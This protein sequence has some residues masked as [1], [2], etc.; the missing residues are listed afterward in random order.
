MVGFQSHWA[1]MEPA[2]RTGA[3]GEE[4]TRLKGNLN[5]ALMQINGQQQAVSRALDELGSGPRLAVTPSGFAVGGMPAP[6][7]ETSGPGRSCSNESD[8]KPFSAISIP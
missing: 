7:E 6:A 4:L 1:A 8:S 3:S 5:H 2:L